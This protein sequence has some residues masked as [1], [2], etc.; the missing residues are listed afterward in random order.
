[1]RSAGSVEQLYSPSY[2]SRTSSSQSITSKGTY[3]RGLRKLGEI[4]G[5]YLKLQ[6]VKDSDMTLCP[7]RLAGCA[8]H[9]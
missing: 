2:G 5:T 1:M 4:P 6:T 7:C 8:T 9:L 3:K